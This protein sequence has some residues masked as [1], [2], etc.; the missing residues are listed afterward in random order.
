MGFERDGRGPQ[1]G[2]RSQPRVTHRP[3]SAKFTS[4]GH[5][6]VDV[7]DARKSATL[8]VGGLPRNRV[9]KNV[10]QTGRPGFDEFLELKRCPI[11]V[12]ACPEPNEKR[13]SPQVTE[14]P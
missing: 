12:V 11:E 3:A 10:P 1:C 2:T 13:G 6:G 7:T 4:V 14:G 8:I 9:P 5:A